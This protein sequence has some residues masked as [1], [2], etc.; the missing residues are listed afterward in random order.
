MKPKNKKQATILAM[1]G[2]LSPLTTAQKR[3]AFNA[4]ISH[5]AYRLKSGKAVC[6]DCGHEWYE[7]KDGKCRCPKCGAMVEIKDTK[8]R[9]LKE[10]SYFNI[11]TSMGDY[12]I[13]RMF[14]M[15]AEMRKG[16]KA[17]PAYL[18]IGQYW[19]DPKGNKTVIGLQRTLGH[20]IDTFSFGSPLEI[21]KDN[22][23]FWRIADQWVYPYVKTTDR[24][25]RNG[26]K[27]GCHRIHPVTLFQQLLTNPKAETLMKSGDTELLRYLCNHQTEFDR[28]WDSVKIARRNGYKV[29]DSQMWFDYI[30]ML[31]TIGKDIHNPKYICPADLRAAHDEYVGKVN[32]RREMERKERERQQAIKDEA[33]FKELKERF[34]G[35]A[36]TDGEIEMHTPQSIDEY[37]EIGKREHICVGTSRYY[38]KSTSLVFIATIGRKQIATVEISLKDYSILQCRAFANG[39][40][41]Y[42]DRI[43]RIVS[44]NTELIANKQ[45]A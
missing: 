6:M 1:S 39:I 21:R 24:I 40:C 17:N 8:E 34:F 26:F 41:K 44:D 30:R 3:W 45:T 32:R 42:A 38:L 43:A 4:T 20:Y 25:R 27:G 33:T 37:Y 2:Q 10:M 29:E 31:E 16:L 13:V 22:E 9:V 5:Y 23:A 14:L 18:E 28:Y 35:L 11:I 19:I 15:I 12:Q 7:E 36:L